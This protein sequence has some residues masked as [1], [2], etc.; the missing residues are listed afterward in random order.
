MTGNGFDLIQRATMKVLP[1]TDEFSEETSPAE[2]SVGPG[3]RRR[4]VLSFIICFLLSSSSVCP[5]GSEGERHGP[6]VRLSGGEL[7][8]Q[9]PVSA[10]LSP[11]GQCGGG[12]EELRLSP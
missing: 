4:P 1:S 6:A 12:A 10:D 11:P 7:L 3:A 8:L 2:V 5:G 9:H